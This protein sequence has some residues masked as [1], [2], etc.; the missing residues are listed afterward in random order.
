[1]K[2]LAR[3]FY[4]SILRA[5]AVLLLYGVAWGA[6]LQGPDQVAAGQGISFQTSGSGSTM[7]YV[8]GPG[9]AIKREITLGET[10]LLRPE[11]LRS[12]GRYL[13][14][15][16]D[17]DSTKVFFVVAGA[18]ASVTFLA[19]PSRVAASQPD[20]ISGVAFVYDQYKNMA[21]AAARV[22]FNLS[23]EG[24]VVVDQSVTSNDGVAY[25]KADSPARAGAAQFVATVGDSNPAVRRVVTLTAGEPCSL[26]MS[27]HR[28]GKF[29]VAETDPI[30]DC[31]G[32]PVPD[33]TIVTFTESEA[34]TGWRSQVDAR[35]K[36][37]I[38]R[39]QLPVSNDAT[40]SVASG[41]KLGNEIHVGG[42]A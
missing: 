2:P 32:N 13:A 28:D 27:V 10:V 14:S 12:A 29:L 16:G 26:R 21:P 1:M 7:L 25:V 23:V 5:A 22:R 18:P 41:I 3:N 11:E 42:G 37:G 17:A 8:E 6:E 20:A 4:N 31:S 35:I 39:A 9:T 19:R 40:I 15:L 33:G 30:K 38:A 36:R 24:K 34:V